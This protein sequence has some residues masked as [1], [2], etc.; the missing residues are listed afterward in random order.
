MY[1]D[2]IKMLYKIVHSTYIPSLFY[3][4]NSG[5]DWSWLTTVTPLQNITQLESY[6]LSQF[7]AYLFSNMSLT[8]IYVFLGFMSHFFSAWHSNPMLWMHLL[9]LLFSKTTC[10]CPSFS[11]YVKW[12]RILYGHQF[13]AKEYDG[14]VYSKVVLSFLKIFLIT[15][16][17]YLSKIFYYSFYLLCVFVYICV[18]VCMYLWFVSVCVYDVCVTV[19][20]SVYVWYVSVWMCVMSVWLCACMCVLTFERMYLWRSE[21][22]GDSSLLQ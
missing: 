7:A 9:L 3:L 10:L 11:S 14:S 12:L 18:C 4:S 8:I 20:L 13:S 19:F 17:S 5:D 15:F 6:S 1:D 16:L 22:N 21:N 2:T